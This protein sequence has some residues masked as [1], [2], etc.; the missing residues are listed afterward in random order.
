MKHRPQLINVIKNN[1]AITNTQSYSHLFLF[2][3]FF[4][5]FLFFFTSFHQSFVQNSYFLLKCKLMYARS[6]FFVSLIFWKNTNPKTRTHNQPTHTHTHI[7]THPHTQGHTLVSKLKRWNYI[8]NHKLWKLSLKNGVKTMKLWLQMKEKDG[9]SLFLLFL[10]VICCF[11]YIFVCIF[12]TQHFTNNFRS[13]NERRK[14]KR[15]K[16][17]KKL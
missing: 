1:R 12:K 11:F 9:L 8:W 17:Q 16:K 13:H 4:L 3:L 10:F 15:K 14:D 6:F 5:C 2:F 7:H